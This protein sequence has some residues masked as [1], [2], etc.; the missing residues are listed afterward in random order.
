MPFVHSVL[1]RHRQFTFYGVGRLFGYNNEWLNNFEIKRSKVKV[2][3]WEQQCKKKLVHHEYLREKWDRLTSNQHQN[4]RPPIST[5]CL[6][7]YILQTETRKR[8]IC[9]ICLFFC[10]IFFLWIAQ[11]N[12]APHLNFATPSILLRDCEIRY[13]CW[14]F[15]GR[16][17][18][19]FFIGVFLQVLWTSPENLTWFGVCA[20]L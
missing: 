6:R 1:E 8:V 16:R 14:N 11:K 19:I 3:H 15:S 5:Q 7:R 17:R 2:D 18:R 9:D 12:G 13:C 4:D 10:K 20:I